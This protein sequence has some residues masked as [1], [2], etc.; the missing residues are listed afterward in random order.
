MLVVM[1]VMTVVVLGKLVY[2]LPRTSRAAVGCADRTRRRWIAAA[3]APAPYSGP[4]VQFTATAATITPA[5][6]NTGMT[7]YRYVTQ[8]SGIRTFTD[9]SLVRGN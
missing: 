9:T 5:A 7:A 8:Q 2:V 6:T 1:M 4:T 3:D